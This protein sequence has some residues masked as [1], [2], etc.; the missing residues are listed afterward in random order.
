M[1]SVLLSPWSALLSACVLSRIGSEGLGR[2]KERKSRDEPSCRREGKQWAESRTLNKTR[3]V[4]KYLKNKE[5]R[6]K[7]PS[8]EQVVRVSLHR[9]QGVRGIGGGKTQIS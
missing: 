3:A 9:A 2:S 8:V 5:K 7:R 1:N 4:R 6:G